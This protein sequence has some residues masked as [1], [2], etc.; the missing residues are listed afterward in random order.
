MIHPTAIIDERAQIHPSV[1][2]GAYAI[3]EGPAKIAA[4]VVIG[5]HAHI[6]GDTTIGKG[7]KI[8][9]AAVI[10]E[11]PQDRSF[12]PATPSQT[13]IGENNVI[14]EQATVHRGSK[15]GSATRL[16]D[17]NFIMA[18][19]HF[20]HD[21]QVGDDNIVA[22]GVL[23]GGHVHVGNHTFMGG[24]AVFHQFVRVGDYCVLQGNS[25]WAHDVPPYCG[26][27]RI[28]RLTGLNVI[29]L[30]RSGFNSAERAQIKELFVLM[31]L[32]GRNKAQALAEARTRQWPPHCEKFLQFFEAPSKRGICRVRA[33]ESDED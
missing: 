31:L 3:I 12:D 9:R 5:A 26:G 29:G 8:G 13:I 20:G 11:D 22:N 33:G 18:N 19:A 2:V 7:T 10:G 17:R 16:G 1:K 21:S 25:G 14:R 6:V 28:N 15:P 24:G 23:I 32:S 27:Q 4:D 30:R